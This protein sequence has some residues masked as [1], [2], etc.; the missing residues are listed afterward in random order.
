MGARPRLRAEER[1]DPEDDL[2]R[3]RR[4]RNDRL[5]GV[6]EDDD[7]Q[8]LE[9]RPE[10]RDLEGLPDDRRGRPRRRRRG[11]RGGVLAH[12][13]EDQPLLIAGSRAAPPERGG[14]SAVASAKWPRAP[15]SCNCALFEQAA[16]TSFLNALWKGE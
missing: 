9:P 2:R 6:L 1:G 11:E 3:R 15:M 7:A 13:E 4:R 8:D 14:N 10:G 16:N 12:H 5:R